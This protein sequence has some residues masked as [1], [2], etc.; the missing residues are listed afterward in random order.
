MPCFTP[1]TAYRAKSSNALDYYIS[2]KPENPE[3][4]FEMKLPCGQCLGCR[5][6][7]AANWAARCVH[8]ASL[9]DKNCFLTLTYDDDHLPENNSL[10]KLDMQ[11]FLKRL[12]KAY[13]KEKYGHIGYFLSGEYGDTNGRPHYHALLFNFDFP[14]KKIWKKGKHGD[15]LYTSEICQKIWQ[16]KGYCVLGNVTSN[17]AAYVARYVV[18]KIKGRSAS[19]YYGSRIPEFSLCSKKPAIGLEWIKKYHSDIFNYD[20]MILEGRKL[21]PARYY[22]KYYEKNFPEKYSDIKISREFTA[23]EQS[24]HPEKFIGR[25]NVKHE[26]RLLLQKNMNRGVDNYDVL[27]SNLYD[28]QKNYDEKCVEYFKEQLRSF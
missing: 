24:N 3:N 8:E 7:H 4:L 18:K 25:T 19:D 10:I 28:S 5:L 21:R 13:P 2:F 16:N 14:D 23:M 12:R 26:L 20:Q 27:V 9:H 11:L 17:S 1:L 22:D 15:S 6:D